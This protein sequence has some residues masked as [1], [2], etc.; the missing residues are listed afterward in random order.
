M[1]RYAW[2]V[3]S[4][5]GGAVGVGVIVIVVEV[6]VVEAGGESKG[7]GQEEESSGAGGLGDGEV[8]FGEETEDAGGVGGE[9]EDKGCRWRDFDG[10]GRGRNY[11][12]P[13]WSE[14]ARPSYS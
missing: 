3:K 5:V 2:C 12:P 14:A 13:G 8:M 4:E 6:G 7:E 1:V 10:V 11:V 9:L